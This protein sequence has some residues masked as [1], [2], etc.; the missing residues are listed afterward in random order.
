M[1]AHPASYTIHLAPHTLH[2]PPYALHPTPYTLHPTPYTLHPTTM[3]LF[4]TVE[5][6]LFIQS[7]LASRNQSSGR[8]C[9][10]FGHATFKSVKQ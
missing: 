1:S 9:S 6:G 5:Y 4:H 3:Q 2:P 8:I 7:Q 10:R